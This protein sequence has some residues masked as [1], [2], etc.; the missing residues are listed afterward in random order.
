LLRA[1]RIAAAAGL[2][3][4]LFVA[5]GVPSVIANLRVFYGL[6][7]IAMVVPLFAGMFAPR[8]GSVPTLASMV[9]ALAVA[10]VTIAWY[11]DVVAAGFWPFLFGTAAGAATCG[12]VV[13]VRPG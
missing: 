10:M 11:G 4:G 13:T 12:V 7:V 1:G 6:L 8:V 5:L 9:V 3:L 2:T